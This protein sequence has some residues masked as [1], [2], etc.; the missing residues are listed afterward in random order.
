MEEIR[1]IAQTPP[2]PLSLQ[3][4][5][6]FADGSKKMRLIAGSFLHKELQIRFARWVSIRDP[7]TRAIL[8]LI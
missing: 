7:C 4:M 3:Q 8:L 6:L 2:T 1:E 5:K